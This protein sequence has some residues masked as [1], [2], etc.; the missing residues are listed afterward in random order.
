VSVV[1]SVHNDAA[2]L[3]EA[4]ASVLAQTLTDLE[5]IVVDDA[6]T[7]ATPEILNGFA[8]ERVVR[9]R[10]DEQLGLA[11]SL[12]RALDTAQGDYVARLDADDVAVPERL[13][14]QLTR[15][16]ADR[17]L[18]VVGSAVSDL[19][20]R[21]V[22]GRTHRNP[23][24]TRGVRWLAFFSSPFFHP[25]VLVD[26]ARLEEHRLRYDPACLESEDY[27]LWTRLLQHADG[28]NLPDALVRK[29]VHPRQASLRRADVQSDFQ[30]R[31]ALREIARLAPKVDAE[32]AWPVGARRK[33]GSRRE[34]VRLLRT[35]E[36]TYGPDREVRI[37]AL[38]DVFS[39]RRRA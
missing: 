18:S 30:R 11:T 4:V 10:N 34:Y 25:T 1:L 17:R 23:L 37:A 38:R 9:M 35:F 21:G 13:E 20:E 22:V 8:D 39:P 27:D 31:I 15:L 5:L 3:G 28:A 33:D 24:G 14:R 6:S 16:R 2:F 32:R 7:D 36:R 29:R 12:N 26:R 19:D